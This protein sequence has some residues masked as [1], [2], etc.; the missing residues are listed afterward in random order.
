MNIDLLKVVWMRVESCTN[1]NSYGRL[2][3]S[4][5]KFNGP[6]LNVEVYDEVHRQRLR[7]RD[8]SSYDATFDLV[9][10]D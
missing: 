7:I 6:G 3:R 1:H 4:V 8:G 2:E 9:K 5:D 10:N